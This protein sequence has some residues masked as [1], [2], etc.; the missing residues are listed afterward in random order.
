MSSINTTSAKQNLLNPRAKKAT[1]KLLL[2]AQNVSFSTPLVAPILGQFGINIKQF[3]QSFNSRTSAIKPGTPLVVKIILFTDNSIEFHFQ[4][5][6]T[7]YF[8]QRVRM[9]RTVHIKSIYEIALIKQK[10]FPNLPLMSICSFIIASART[11]K[12]TLKK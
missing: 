5:P 2:E 11:H 6:S 10:D 3:C 7:T 1:I 4:A 12:L 8:L 9:N